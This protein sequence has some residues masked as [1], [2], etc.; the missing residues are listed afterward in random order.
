MN[1]PQLQPRR[2]AP[3]RLP[4]TFAPP[5]GAELRERLA[6]LRERF[7]FRSLLTPPDAN[8]KLA[9][10]GA[11]AALTLA[12]AALSGLDVCPGRSAECS[13]AC[14]LWHAGNGYRS[15]VRDARVGRTLAL[16]ADPQAVLAG[17]VAEAERLA[18][19]RD[20]I[21]GLRLNCAS[22]LPFERV[23]GFLDALPRGL[24]LWD[25][26]KLPGR[27]GDNGQ[28]VGA[29]RPYRL[30]FSVSERPESVRRATEIVR[31]GGSAVVVV[32]GLRRRQADGTLK[33]I[34]RPT[35][36]RIGDEWFPAVD[37]DRTDRRD[38]DPLGVIVILAGKGRLELPTTGG[39]RI[40]ERFAV[41]IDSPDL[42]YR[43][44]IRA[45][46]RR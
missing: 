42:R 29:S 24:G 36:A 15:S 8:A 9:K 10:R 14:V 45:A 26:T 21:R 34:A 3:L 11:G 7:G 25:Y 28:A 41:A 23:A 20:P 16:A 13:A 43:S 33:Y 35:A 19:G 39:D 46:W 2:P 22:D 40:G 44:A 4:A 37:G 12:P 5:S 18:R 1:L 38:L 32:A 27:I 31:R 30:A 6:E 17:V